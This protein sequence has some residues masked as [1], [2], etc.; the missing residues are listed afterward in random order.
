MPNSRNW[1]N[2]FYGDGKFIIANYSSEGIDGY[3]TSRFAYSTD[4]TTWN[5]GTLPAS[6]GWWGSCV[7]EVD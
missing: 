4:G 3:A 5:T 1:G 7:G 6:S 2:P